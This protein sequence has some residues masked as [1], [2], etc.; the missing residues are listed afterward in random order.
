[1]SA[2]KPAYTGV[3]IRYFITRLRIGGAS[4]YSPKKETSYNANR[5]MKRIKTYL[6]AA[7]LASFVGLAGAVAAGVYEAPVYAV[8]V[9]VATSPGQA[10]PLPDGT[11]GAIQADGRTCCPKGTT[12]NTSCLFKKYINPA[13]Q[14]LSALV[15]VAVVSSVIYGGIEYITSEGDPQK[16]AAGK[17][18]ITNGLIGLAA[19]ILL[20]AFLQF[21]IPGGVLNG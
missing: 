15:G 9:Y 21:I 6:L 13:V 5:H 19:F 7:L 14:L 10:C 11:N 8:S 17:E 12:D 1:M 4:R 2:K 18:H 20:Y 16:S 3:G